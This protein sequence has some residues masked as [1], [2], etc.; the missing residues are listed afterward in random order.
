[1]SG[2]YLIKLFIAFCLLL[3]AFT[4]CSDKITFTQDIR[5]KL[6]SQNIDIRKIQFYNSK[7]VVLNR[8]LNS[9]ELNVSAGD[10]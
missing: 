10:T 4:S 5:K 9:V 7:R 3:L 2:K 6:E 1:M 8:K